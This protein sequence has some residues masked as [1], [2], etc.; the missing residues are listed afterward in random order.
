MEIGRQKKKVTKGSR[1]N[2][3]GGT[4]R[5]KKGGV[6]IVRN[7]LEE[8]EEHRKIIFFSTALVNNK[9]ATDRNSL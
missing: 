6:W 4:E 3:K 9:N 7:G 2:E 5:Q 1:A 8:E